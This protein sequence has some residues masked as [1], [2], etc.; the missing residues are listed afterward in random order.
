MPGT[1]AEKRFKVPG[2][3]P[4]ELD[5]PRLPRIHVEG[6]IYYVTS[7]SSED[8]LI[9][10]EKADY[11]MY[12]DLLAKYKTQHGFK[13]FSY[14]LFPDSLHL[15]I[16]TSSDSTISDIMHD[17]NSLYTKYYNGR[18]ARKG[19]LFESRFK[20]VLVEKVNHLLEMT[21]YIHRRPDSAEYPYSSYSVYLYKDGAAPSCDGAVDM[22]AEIAEV[23]AFLKDKN[24]PS[25]YERYC[26]SG[27]EEI[28]ELDKKL[29][30]ASLLGSEAFAE[31]AQNRVKEQIESAKNAAEKTAPSRTFL[32]VIGALVVLAVGSSIYLYVNNRRLESRYAELLSE[33][34]ETFKQDTRFENRSPIAPSELEGTVWRTDMISS[35]APDT[36]VKDKLVFKDGQLH[37]DYFGVLGFGSAKYFLVPQ[38]AGIVNWQ[39][40]VARKDGSTVTWRATW[41][42]GSMKGQVEV[43]GPQ[44][45]AFSFFSD[46]WSYKNAE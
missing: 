33:Q 23:L 5:L 44:A 42:A 31:A 20:S 18:Y 6:A 13:I 22:R 40:A 29:K 38:G 11:K 45:Q 25:A 1:E 46:K 8:Q 28:R 32:F 4:K 24:D 9:F 36:T 39:A 3:P 7:K 10:R 19:P 37:S 26:L 27:D 43:R 35:D 14:C 17:L 16:E 41:K 12:L 21:R 30:R 15:L 34:A 2:T